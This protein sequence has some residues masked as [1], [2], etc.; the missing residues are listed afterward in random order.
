M[1]SSET[2]EF[3]Q[4]ASNLL[5]I[6]KGKSPLRQAQCIAFIPLNKGEMSDAS[7]RCTELVEVGIFS[8]GYLYMYIKKFS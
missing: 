7:R 2:I 6:P 1:I 5:K 3:L 4:I 8:D